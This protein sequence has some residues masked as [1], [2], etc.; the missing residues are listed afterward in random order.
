MK[1]KEDGKAASGYGAGSYKERILTVDNSMTGILQL[2]YW[3]FWKKDG[4]FLLHRPRLQW[5]NAAI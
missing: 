2:F 3:G 1:K 4:R 5:S